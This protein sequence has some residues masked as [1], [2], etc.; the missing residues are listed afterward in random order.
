[1]KEIDTSATPPPPPK[2]NRI[3]WEQE[4]IYFNTVKLQNT[5]NDP[6]IVPKRMGQAKKAGHF[7]LTVSMIPENLHTDKMMLFR[8]SQ[9]LRK[10]NGNLCRGN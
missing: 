5:N 4:Q 9:I 7:E 10:N 8:V 1:M 6:K 3:C 2:K